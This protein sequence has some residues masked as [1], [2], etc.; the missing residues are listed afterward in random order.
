VTTNQPDGSRA[1]Q[2]RLANLRQELMAPASAILGYA[3]ILHED[4]STTARSEVATDLERIVC[5][6]RD[7]FGMVDRLLDPDLAE[8]LFEGKDEAEAGNKLR[9]DLRTPINAIKGYSEM[10]LEDLEDLDIER[11][12]GDF[13]SLLGEANRL[14]SQLD[15]I[16]DF[17]RGDPGDA[18]KA[19]QDPEPTA[20]MFAGLVESMRPVSEADRPR[21]TGRI[22]VVDDLE[23]NRELL[24]RRLTREGHMTA[25]APG[26]RQALALLEGKGIDLVLLDLMMPDMNGFDVL[27]RMKADPRFFEIPV[28]MISALDEMDSVIRCIEAGAEDYLPK[29]FNPVLLNARIGACLEKRHL[30]ERERLYLERL[31]DEKEKFEKLLLNILPQQIVGRLNGG[32]TIIADRVDNVSVLFSDLVGFTSLSSEL[33]PTRLVEYLNALF[34]RFDALA[35]ELGVEKI[36]MIGD[37]YMAVAGVPEPRP[38]HAEAIA[39]MALGMMEIVE[40]GNETAEF[41][42]KVRIGIHSGPV[43]AGIIGTHRFLYDIWGDTVNLASRLESLS[44]ANRVQVSEATARLLAEG[45]DLEAR[46]SIRVKG[47]GVVKTY[48]LNAITAQPAAVERVRSS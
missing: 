7:L 28:I 14:L 17:S 2:A 26:G 13:E 35:G 19:A 6:A 36:K 23:T 45:F 9:H 37:A 34:S 31:E 33:A 42:L 48:F 40:R 47:K 11:L 32:E 20:A 21:E 46:G 39:R 15:S 4:A 43:V 25:T 8:G 30:R 24:S 41:P 12:R 38:D 3:E 18:Q 22:L 1:R 16:V 29:P 44:L 27:A 10:L 5:S